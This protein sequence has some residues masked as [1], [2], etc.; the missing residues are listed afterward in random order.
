ME[1]VRN[2]RGN[3]RVLLRECIT[4]LFA[5]AQ[6]TCYCDPRV[7]LGKMYVVVHA[8]KLFIKRL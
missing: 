5:L 7:R 6:V 4:A 8:I 2:D 1:Q 3:I